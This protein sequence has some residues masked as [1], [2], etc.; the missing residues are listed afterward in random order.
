[1][2]GRALRLGDP[3]GL[4]EGGVGGDEGFGGGSEGQSGEVEDFGGAG[5][6]G[7]VVGLEVV[8]GG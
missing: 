6:D 1:M 4:F 3:P 7:E 2:D 8:R 5:V